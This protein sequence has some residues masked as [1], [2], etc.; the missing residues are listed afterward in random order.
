MSALNN[1]FFVHT[2]FQFF[3]AQQI[4]VQE[5]LENNVLL[6]GSVGRNAQFYQA[7]D[8]MKIESFWKA[9][10]YLDDLSGWAYIERRNLLKSIA[11]LLKHD[12]FINRILRK[13]DIRVLYLGDLNNFSCKFAAV[14]FRRKG[15]RIV[16]YE[17]GTSH[18]AF[19]QH[20]QRGGYWVNVLCSLMTDICVY[21]PY[22]HFCYGKYRFLKDRT[23]DQLPVYRRYSIVPLYK[24]SFDKKLVVKLLMSDALQD[25]IQEEEKS[26]GLKSRKEQE[27]ILFLSQPIYDASGDKE[28]VLAVLKGYFSSYNQE[29]LIVVKFHPREVMLVR[30]EILRLLEELHLNYCVLSD[31]NALPVE[32]YLQCFTFDRMVTFASST[33][34]YG[35][36]IYKGFPVEVLLNRYIEECRRRN[37]DVS[38][39]LKIQGML[40]LMNVN[41][42]K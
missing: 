15:I 6:L 9:T 7:Y 21:L 10:Y 31:R 5:K 38:S 33:V 11:C 16:F 3:V 36:Y 18:Y 23:I 19:Q 35:G 2:P 22:F 37:F 17:E 28:T 1:L 41:G 27:K 20:P 12:R 25:Y 34:L 8:L 39:L 26:M 24:E 29:T 32:V 40:K 14:R 30:K 13:H 42:D 4:I